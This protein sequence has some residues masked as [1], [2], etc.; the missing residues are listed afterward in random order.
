MKKLRNAINHIK[1][2]KDTYTAVAQGIV[3]GAGVG[4][5]WYLGARWGVQEGVRQTIK[6]LDK[7]VTEDPN[8]YLK[9]VPEALEQITTT[10]VRFDDV[11]DV[12]DLVL[13]HAP[14][15]TT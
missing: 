7:V 12:F 10:P 6:V 3:I 9:V 11:S 5:V 13:I 15:I 8:T 14:K 1:R 2:N 4:T